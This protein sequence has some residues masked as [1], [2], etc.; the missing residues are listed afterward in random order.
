MYESQQIPTI[1]AMGTGTTA[2]DYGT[3]WNATPPTLG[4]GGA[5]RDLF[6]CVLPIGARIQG[7]VVSVTTAITSSFSTLTMKLRP[8]PGSDTGAD[9]VGTMVLQAASAKDLLQTF[10]LGPQINS[11]YRVDANPGEELVIAI[12]TPGGGAGA[13]YVFPIITWFNTNAVLTA[14]TDA[15]KWGSAPAG[16]VITI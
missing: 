4:T 15:K 8:T 3:P 10:K 12:G 6:K 1:M 11:A 7:L 9:T 5:A 14:R 2:A 16:N 13:G